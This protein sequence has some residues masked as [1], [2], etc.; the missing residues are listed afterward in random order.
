MTGLQMAPLSQDWGQGPEGAAVV[1]T[2]P[3]FTSQQG[4]GGV[5]GPSPSPLCAGFPV[6]TTQ[7]LL[8]V[9]AAT[10]SCREV[11]DTPSSVHLPHHVSGITWFHSCT[12]CC[13][14][15]CQVL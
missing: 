10:L 1:L 7:T 8:R 2:P 5:P 13:L 4:D 11:A 9:P 15:L 14:L 12:G 3:E 6:P